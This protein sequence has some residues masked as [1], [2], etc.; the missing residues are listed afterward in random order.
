MKHTIILLIGLSIG[1]ISYAEDTIP[2][3]DT[4]KTWWSNGSNEQITIDDRGLLQITLKD[5]ETAY[6]LDVEIFSR[7]RNSQDRTVMVRPKLR[8]VKEIEG[9]VCKDSV[10][11]D[12]D[13]DGISEV[14]TVSLGSGQ[15]ITRGTKSI[16]QFDGWT[17]VVLHQAEF[18]DN[19]G[20][21]GIKD[22]RFYST[23]VAWEFRDLDGDGNDDLVETIT[24][25]KGRNNKNPITNSRSYK[26]VF[27]NNE[28]TRPID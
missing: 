11:H 5:H 18:K 8:E 7:G 24:T 21:W 26:Y 15:G 20:E 17:P 23:S 14:E 3:I 25:K 1:N 27:K 28:F 2:T 13:H 6:L 16:V 9:P 4:I 10:V 22:N 19:E 12:L